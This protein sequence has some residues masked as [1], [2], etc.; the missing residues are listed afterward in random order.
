MTSNH[1][2]ILVQDASTNLQACLSLI[3][4]EF[5]H[6]STKEYSLF[7]SSFWK[8]RHPFQKQI[9]WSY[10]R[11]YI[12]RKTKKMVN[13]FLKIY[14]KIFWVCCVKIC[15]HSFM[16]IYPKIIQ[17][18]KR[19]GKRRRWH[20][21]AY[22][23]STLDILWW[24]YLL[25][26]SSLLSSPLTMLSPFNQYN[27]ESIN[28]YVMS[29]FI[30]LS[31]SIFLFSTFSYSSTVKPFYILALSLSFFPSSPPLPSHNLGLKM[32]DDEMRTEDKHSFGPRR[33]W[34]PYHND[35]PSTQTW[36]KAIFFLC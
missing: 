23:R 5:Q 11:W 7:Y 26:N 18:G 17:K 21:Y 2:S 25:Q 4:V 13:R 3:P 20:W 8:K 16:S 12:A 29:C 24:T 34:M 6:F 36:K 27:M 14:S 10:N 33:Q 28:S 15:V 9:S 19:G 32:A 31:L 1:I 35:M 22:V 30:A